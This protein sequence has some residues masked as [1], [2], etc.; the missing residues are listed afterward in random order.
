MTS[1]KDTKEANKNK[2]GNAEIFQTVE[3]NGCRF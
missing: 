2:D 3:K 1:N